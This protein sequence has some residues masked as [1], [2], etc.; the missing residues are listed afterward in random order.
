MTEQD[1]ELLRV[2]MEYRE[3]VLDSKKPG[4]DIFFA[5]KRIK[6]I[7]KHET[8][9]VIMHG[10][11]QGIEFVMTKIVKKDKDGE[12]YDLVVDGQVHYSVETNYG[13]NADGNRG[14]SKL[15]IDD[16]THVCG[17]VNDVQVKL[18]AEDEFLAEEAL[19][20][21]LLERGIS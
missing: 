1:K 14:W 21:E 10:K 4:F 3:A 8:G 7:F 12:D 16:V 9:G 13:A 19:T 20:D 18:S 2:L 17:Y 5:H 6:D 11:K 15:F